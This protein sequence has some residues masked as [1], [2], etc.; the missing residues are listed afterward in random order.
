MHPKTAIIPLHNFILQVK[1]LKDE[2]LLLRENSG[3]EKGTELKTP[4]VNG[5]LPYCNH[6]SQ[7]SGG[8]VIFCTTVESSSKEHQTKTSFFFL[9]VF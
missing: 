3:L 8:K 2:N 6:T 5:G 7:R 9:K 1:R 4:L